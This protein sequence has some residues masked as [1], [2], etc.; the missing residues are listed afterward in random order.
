M[1]CVVEES[2]G[3]TLDR[4]GEVGV[5]KNADEVSNA[6]LRL[7]GWAIDLQQKFAP[8]WGWDDMLQTLSPFGNL[9]FITG[10]TR[11]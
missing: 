1:A 4:E 5:V 11:R 2:P 10:Y 3:Q 7:A 9:L 8:P 6:Y